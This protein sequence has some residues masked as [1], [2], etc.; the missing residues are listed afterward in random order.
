MT[1]DPSRVFDS[2]RSS[3]PGVG[4]PSCDTAL[5][6]LPPNRADPHGYY[7]EIG[8]PPWA[9]DGEIKSAVRALYR[10]LHPDTGSRPDPNRL[11]RVK[12]I[13]EVLLD[14]AERDKYN[15]T[16]AGKRLLDKV[17]RSELSALDVLS[18]LTPDQ[19]DDA[20]RP[21]SADPT[22]SASRAG[23]WYDYLAVDR[24]AGD[25]HLAQRWYE[26]LVRASWLVGYRRRIK[27]LLHDG[28]AFYHPETAV[29]A[30]PRP[31]TPSLALAFGLFVAVAGFGPR[32]PGSRHGG[33]VV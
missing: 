22:G 18:G 6:R 20:L 1:S 33:G 21:V 16:P 9:S 19:L 3:R 30:V 4:F 32:N 29:L 7:A 12:L 11:T 10:R 13:A 5:C 2:R 17:Y 31:W 8:V 26:C 24:R 27:V 15:R 23:E 28:P 25:M 14:P